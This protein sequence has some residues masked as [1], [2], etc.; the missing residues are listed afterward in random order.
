MTDKLVKVAEGIMDAAASEWR[1]EN[2]RDAAAV[3]QYA[4]GGLEIYL[5]DA[6]AELILS[7]CRK[8]AARMDA[9][10]IVG[11]NDWY[12]EFESP[13]R[14]AA[15]AALGS[16]KTPAKAAAARENGKKGGR[17]TDLELVEAALERA[18]SLSGASTEQL[19]SDDAVWTAQVFDSA[20]LQL[21]KRVQERLGSD[22]AFAEAVNELDAKLRASLN[23]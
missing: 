13:L 14:S 11:S 2:L 17:P 1:A 8:M 23:E 10:E 18:L 7:V 12:H 9:G 19:I 4:A 3:K 15:A 5:N 21:P 22:E 6:E 16:S 20:Y